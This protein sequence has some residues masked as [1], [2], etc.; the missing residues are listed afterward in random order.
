MEVDRSGMVVHFEN[1]KA[2][3]MRRLGRGPVRYDLGIAEVA[4]K[5]G[6]FE[7]VAAPQEVQRAKAVGGIVADSAVAGI[8]EVPAG[9]RVEGTIGNYFEGRQIAME[10]GHSQAIRRGE[11]T[12]QGQSQEPG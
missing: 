9:H 7:T 8:V 12:K 4:R 11:A 6:C 2:R 10:V 5:A 3:G 1:G